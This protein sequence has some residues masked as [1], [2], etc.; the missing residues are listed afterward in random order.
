M[1]FQGIKSAS[2]VHKESTLR[3]ILL[4]QDLAYLFNNE[5]R[6]YLHGGVLVFLYLCTC[7]MYSAYGIIKICK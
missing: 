1:W 4:P 2:A 3:I 6:A 7:A 5:D